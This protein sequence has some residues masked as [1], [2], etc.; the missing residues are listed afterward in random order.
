MKRKGNKAFTLIEMVV[1]TAAV[2]MIMV[3]LVSVVL[4]TFKSQNQSKSSSKVSSGGNW[5]L[6]ELKRNVLSSNGQNIVCNP[7]NLS[8]GLT[9]VNDGDWTTISCSSNRIAS[10]SASRTIYLDSSDIS[11]IDC[12]QFVSCSVL[13]SLEVS[14]VSFNFGVGASTVGIGV[15]QHFEIDMTLRD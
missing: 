5:I 10:V 6:N 12:S 1:V 11:I 2:A 14:V 13:P 7:N 8:I 9:N 3:A 15:T 4:A